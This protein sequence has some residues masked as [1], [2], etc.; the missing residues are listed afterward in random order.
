[1]TVGLFAATRSFVTFGLLAVTRTFVYFGLPVVMHYFVSLG[2][3]SAMDLATSSVKIH[4]VLISSTVCFF[5][6][7]CSTSLVDIKSMHR[8]ALYV[9]EQFLERY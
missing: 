4:I 3:N 1:M 8:K 2:L 9:D 7:R 6:N 5:V